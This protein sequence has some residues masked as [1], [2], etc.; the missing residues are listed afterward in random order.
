MKFG[1][2]GGDNMRFQNSSDIINEY[3]EVCELLIRSCTKN[4]NVATPGGWWYGGWTPIQHAAFKSNEILFNIFAPFVEDP[5]DLD[6]YGESLIQRVGK[7]E[8]NF[9][10]TEKHFLS[11]CNSFIYCATQNYVSLYLRFLTPSSPLSP[12]LLNRLID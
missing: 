11:H 1:Y 9:N 2:P 5:H 7:K 4:P 12:I 6:P 10:F 3:K 8:A